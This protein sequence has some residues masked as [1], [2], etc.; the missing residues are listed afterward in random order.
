MSNGMGNPNLEGSAIMITVDPVTFS[1]RF[2]DAR[3]AAQLT[4]RQLADACEISDRTVSAWET[5]KAEGILAEHLFCVADKLGVDARW[6]AT[7][8]QK[9]PVVTSALAE[10]VRGLEHLPVDQQEA[11]RSLVRSLKR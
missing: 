11:V 6:L 3:E 9:P 4:Q 5:G 1:K 10:I 2:R 8:Q 7:G